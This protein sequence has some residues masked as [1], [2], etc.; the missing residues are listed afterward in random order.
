MDAN[1]QFLLSTRFSDLLEQEIL[2]G[3]NLQR[4]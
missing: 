4:H 3:A 2:P 1:Q